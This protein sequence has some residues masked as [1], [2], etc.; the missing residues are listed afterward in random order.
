MGAYEMAGG[1]YEMRRKS[2]AELAEQRVQNQAKEQ[3]EQCQMDLN[4]AESQWRKA[5]V[6]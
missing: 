6:K 5:K 2:L 3:R 1:K 4:I